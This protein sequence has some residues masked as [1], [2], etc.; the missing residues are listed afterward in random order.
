MSLIEWA[1]ASLRAKRPNKTQHTVTVQQ[2]ECENAKGKLKTQNK[3]AAND[4]GFSL[5]SDML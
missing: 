5:D 3:G 2:Y 1:S 4:Q